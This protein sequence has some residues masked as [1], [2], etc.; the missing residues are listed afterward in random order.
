MELSSFL[1]LLFIS[2]YFSI[3]WSFSNSSSEISIS[4]LS[5]TILNLFKF[6][7]LILTKL[8][9]LELTFKLYF[10][11]T[12]LDWDAILFLTLIKLGV[13]ELAFKLYFN[14]TFLGSVAILFIIILFSFFLFVD[15]SM[16]DF[17]LIL[18]GNYEICSF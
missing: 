7:Y 12:F 14:S 4:F 3:D 17:I 5:I 1:I 11:S 8:G 16:L 10:I 9:V 13:F 6:L 2:S 18:A 15:L